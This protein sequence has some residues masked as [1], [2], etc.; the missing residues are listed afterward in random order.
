MNQIPYIL[1]GWLL[2][3]FSP[4]IVEFFKSRL[5]TREFVAALKVELENLQFRLAISS[6]N[7]LQSHVGLDRDFAIWV[8][9]IVDRYSGDEPTDGIRKFLRKFLGADDS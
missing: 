1:F 2:G 7:L 8:S 6:L 5:H 9:K 3:L 4:L